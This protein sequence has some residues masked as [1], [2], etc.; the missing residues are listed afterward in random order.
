MCLNYGVPYILGIGKDGPLATG[1]S[2]AFRE[3]MQEI[4]ARVFIEKALLDKA[5]KAKLG[6]D[7]A[8]RSISEPAKLGNVPMGIQE[9]NKPLSEHRLSGAGLGILMIAS[10]ALRYG[11]SLTPPRYNSKRGKTVAVFTAELDRLPTSS[12]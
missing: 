7:L 6:A 11:G 9:Q 10:A 12:E 2:E 4:E 3:N 1:R 8:R 5:K